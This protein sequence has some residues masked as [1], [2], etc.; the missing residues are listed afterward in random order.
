MEL[1]PGETLAERLARGPLSINE[2][3]AIFRQITE[4]LEAAH[5]KGIIHRD[6]KP[7]NVI[8][9]PEGRVKVLD[10]GLAKAVTGEA[11]S[12]DLSHS[13]T[14]TREGT[15][16]GVILGT[17][18]YMSPEQARGKTLDR[19]TDIWSF[20]CVFYE[21]LTG[22]KAFYGETVSDVL[23]AILEREPDW[24]ALPARTPETIRAL[25]RWCL[26]KD[27]RE[28]LRDIG[29]ARFAVDEPKP[30]PTSRH[31]YLP[32]VGAALL[33]G[34][35]LG[36]LLRSVPLPERAVSRLTVNLPLEQELTTAND[37]S[38]ALSPDGR[39]LVYVGGSRG[40][41]RLY[42][43][44]LDSLEAR[45]LPGTEAAMTAFFSPDGASVGFY[46]PTKLGKLALD[47]GYSDLLTDVHEPWGASWGSGDVILFSPSGSGGLSLISASG[48]S[49]SVVTTPNAAR[50]EISHRWPEI[51]PDGKSALFTI[52]TDSGTP[53]IGLLSLVTGAY[54][55]LLEGGSCAR[56]QP[57]GH[58]L[59][60]SDG[61]LLAAPFDP[62]RLELTGEPARILGDIWTRPDLGTAHFAVSQDGTLA[63]VQAPE[64]RSRLVWVDHAGSVQPISEKRGDFE[65]PR[66]SPDGRSLSL[67]IREGGKFHIGVYEMERDSFAQLTFGPEEDQAAIWTPD[68]KRMT[69][70][71]G[72][73]SNLF[74][75][76]A[77]G[78]GPEERLTTSAYFQRASSWSPDGKVL[79]YLERRPSV[80]AEDL[81]LLH[82]EGEPKPRPFL[83]TPFRESFGTVSPD[84]RYL[85]YMSNESGVW[86]V[87]VRSFPGAEGKWKISSEG[88]SQPVWARSGRE[89]FYRV[90]DEMMAV[91]VET[92]PQFRAGKPVILFEGAFHYAGISFPQYDVTPD[93][94]R[95]V[96]IEDQEA[97]PTR[98]ELV[99]NW[100]EELK[101]RVPARPR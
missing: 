62:E 6:L 45:P 33:L 18:S 101:A 46:S 11:S 99:L 52:L 13:P 58:L 40:E 34:I 85:A 14:L 36:L 8:V 2:C 67:S 16:H 60:L 70:R 21:A 24:A 29:D 49:P 78:S 17:A 38:L 77:D 71:R 64:P 1:V 93:G 22:K 74:W 42:L 96:M 94:K 100:T 91:A 73:T 5:E 97:W 54:R 7:A 23:A 4:A 48:G 30:A 56:Y 83:E 28:R 84:G 3:L 57:T 87:Y 68:G 19:R 31:G 75:M 47:S 76:P 27:P 50:G 89:I 61:A 41:R 12:S 39:K 98:I 51:L 59:Y 53:R 88:G 37:P 10:F 43:R 32:W 20:G 81:W 86:E 90:G 15:E 79:V 44:S 9:T 35:A 82:L 95:F 80:E 92:E 69:F 63:Y 66:L 72:G 26:E 25:L 55:V 65:D